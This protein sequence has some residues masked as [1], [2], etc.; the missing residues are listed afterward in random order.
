MSERFT[1]KK[2]VLAKLTMSSPYIFPDSKFQK[3]E[4]PRVK[5]K[6]SSANMQNGHHFLTLDVDVFCREKKEQLLEINLQYI[7]IVDVADGLGDDEIN[8]IMKVIV[9]NHIYNEARVLVATLSRESSCPALM[10]DDYSKVCAKASKPSNVGRKGQILNCK[11]LVMQCADRPAYLYYY[12]YFV[13]IKYNHPEDK[14]L[15]VVFWDVLFQLIMG[16]FGITCN[17]VDREN[18]A[19]DLIIT[20]D[21]YVEMSIADM[22]LEDILK[23]AADL[24]GHNG[25]L[26]TDL[27]ALALVTTGPNSSSNILDDKHVSRSE[28]FKMYGCDCNDDVEDVFDDEYDLFFNLNDLDDED[29]SRLHSI[30][31]SMYSKILD[32]DMM[33]LEYRK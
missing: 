2:T 26:I 25:N 29:S 6:S 9:P 31:N 12:R 4:P 10:L 21:R 11:N 27:D 1:I 33:T 14:M 16:D 3:I 28:F 5:V 32:C 13:P 22:P 19:P 18:G 7:A 24:M 8:E 23:L 20:Y 15:G 17:L 30:L